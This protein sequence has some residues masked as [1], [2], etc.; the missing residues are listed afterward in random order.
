MVAV[1]S[2]KTFVNFVQAAG[3]PELVRD[4][5]F[6]KYLDRRTNWPELM[7]LI[8]NWS[9]KLTS[10]QCLSALEL[11]GVPSSPYRTVKQALDD[12]QLAHRRALTPV[13]DLGG[14]FK[15]LNTPFRLSQADTNAGARSP[16]LGEHTREVLHE[17]GY[18]SAQITE[19]DG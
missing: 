7:D 17:I 14:E 9:R 4:P 6:E 2:E 10:E 13:S 18:D 16:A 12:P 3:Q 1:A 19:L 5:R 11:H 15:V 8:E